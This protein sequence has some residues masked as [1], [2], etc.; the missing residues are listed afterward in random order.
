MA[1]GMAFQKPARGHLIT[2]RVD[3]VWVIANTA[4][5]DTGYLRSS[6]GD[7]GAPRME[8][9]TL[10]NPSGIRRLAGEN[11]PFRLSLTVG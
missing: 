3:Q 4:I 7:L 1:A 2:V 10:R 6:R 9:A 8:A 5:K 11:R